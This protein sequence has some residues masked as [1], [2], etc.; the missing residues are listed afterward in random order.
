MNA[1]L[2]DVRLAASIAQFN[3]SMVAFCEEEVSSR[4]FGCLDLSAMVETQGG[5]W[6]IYPMDERSSFVVRVAQSDRRRK[7]DSQS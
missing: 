6:V 4:P 7:L 3:P 1:V 5:V 2:A